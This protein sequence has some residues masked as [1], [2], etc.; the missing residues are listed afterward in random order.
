MIFAWYIGVSLK[1]Y[2]VSKLT[3]VTICVVVLFLYAKFKIPVS[4]NGTTPVIN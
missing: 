3:A 1:F 4:F 2:T